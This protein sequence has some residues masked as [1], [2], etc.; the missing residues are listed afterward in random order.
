M[1]DHDHSKP[2]PKI[3]LYS[4]IAL[5]FATLVL[6]AF[7]R[8]TGIGEVRTPQAAVTAERLLNFSDQADGSILVRDGANG[9]PIDTVAP[10]TN[11][12]LRG[13]LRGLA[14]ERRRSGIGPEPALRLTGRADGR[15][16][17]EDPATGRLVDLGAFGRTNAA[18][19]AQW[20]SA[21][22]RS[23]A[24]AALAAPGH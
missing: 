3:P 11:G 14:R 4:A 24:V 9:L 15:L 19:F 21:P 16:L 7:V 1:H 5:V 6:V 17:L 8:L 22:A 20:L 13:T 18:V 23:P 12:F 2:V 10:G